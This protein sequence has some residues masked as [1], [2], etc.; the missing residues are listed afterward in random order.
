MAG[1]TCLGLGAG[2]ISLFGFFVEPVATEFSVGVATINIA[3]VALLL[4]PGIIAPMVG[5]LV[6]SWPI[7]KMLLGGSAFAMLSLFSISLSSS[8]WQ[9]G[10]GFLGFAIGITFYGPVVVNGLMVKLYS[11]REGRALALAALGISVA[12]V[13]LPPAIGA[14]LAWLDWRQTLAVLSLSLLV[15]LWL[16]ILLGIPAD[17]GAE[18]DAPERSVD[19]GIYRQ[20]EFWL[21]GIT[22]ALTFNAMVILTICYPPLF[23]SRG[24]SAMQA[25]LFLA[26]AGTGGALGKLTVAMLADQLRL[27]ARFF[28]AFL[29]LLKLLGL[30]ML[31]KADTAL[32]VAASV[33]VMGFSG[34]A[35]LPMHPYL[36]SRYFPADV[37]GQVNGAQGPLF[38]P[39][40]LVGPP[41][42][43]YVFDQTGSYSLVLVG[44]AGLL[45]LAVVAVITL[46]RSRF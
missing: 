31:F 9:A 15:V 46:P 13:T 22:V 44:L 10:L 26:A 37:I 4:V 24:F 45:A 34:G 8:L 23:T 11:G 17:A 32:W 5:R 29:L 39:L 41:L 38:L 14:A 1:M 25:G 7:R 2:L 3:P 33:A 20:R 16:W 6:D 19:R 30:M 18:V 42:A 12:S 40:G 35:F 36:N 21:V 27:H 43:G 28:V